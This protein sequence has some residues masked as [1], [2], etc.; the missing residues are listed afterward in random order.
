MEIIYENEVRK[1]PDEKQ[2]E[3]LFE[4]LSDE[5]SDE[6][7]K[8]F[9]EEKLSEEQ[10]EIQQDKTEINL[11]S[12]IQSESNYDIDR[13]FIQ[14]YATHILIV[15]SAVMIGVIGHIFLNSKIK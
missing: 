13:N 9:H 12:D 8:E 7:S 4:K 15:A 11:K 5:E 2:F 1:Q 3:E 14:K 6:E 10:S